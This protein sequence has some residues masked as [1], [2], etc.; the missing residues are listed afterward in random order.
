MEGYYTHK[1]LESMGFKRIGRE[2]LVS[3]KASFYGI[4]NI[5][6]GDNVRIDDFC[7][8]S[9][10]IVIGSH[11]HIASSVLIG[12]GSMGVFMGDFISI[13]H[14]VKIFASSD[15]YSGES[16]ANSVIPA[17]YKNV[18]NE[19]LEFGDFSHI[20]ANSVILPS[21]K[22]ME[23]GVALGAM[24]LLLRKTKP[25]GMYFG[26]PARRVSERSKTCVELKEKFLQE[27][28]GKMR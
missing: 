12:G 25:W 15:D 17:K 28:A 9:G 22:G 4:S 20:G 2:V 7:I 8:F 26:I 10:R 16:M 23:Q 1:E 5:E 13:S 3:K 24:S 27:W 21:S 18:R 6:I 19:K 14:G 11:I